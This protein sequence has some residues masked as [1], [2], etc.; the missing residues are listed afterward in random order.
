MRIYNVAKGQ[1]GLSNSSDGEDKAGSS[2]KRSR[3]VIMGVI[4]LKYLLG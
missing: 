1:E 3:F 4:Q 2:A